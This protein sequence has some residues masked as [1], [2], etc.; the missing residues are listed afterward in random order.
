MTTNQ[1]RDILVAEMLGDIGKLHDQVANLKAELPQILGQMQAVI[2]TQT[3]KAQVLQEPTQRAI[4]HFISQE[5]R[6][7]KVAAKEAQVTAGRALDE[8]VSS[9]VRKNLIWMQLKSEQ[10]FDLITRQFD[11]AVTDSATV[12]E[13]RATAT[14]KGLC[15]G[16]QNHIHEIRTERW[17]GQYLHMLAACVST[18]LV[19]GVFAVYI[20]K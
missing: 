8:D 4:Q 19:V 12:A 1:T 5:I 20:L 14:L 15:Q 7:I 9:A 2:A 16:L 11:R 13:G 17:K 10:T 3:A 18:G 6:G